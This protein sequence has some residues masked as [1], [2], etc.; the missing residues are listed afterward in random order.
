MTPAKRLDQLD[1]ALKDSSLDLVVCPELFMSGYNIGNALPQL[2]EEQQGAYATQVAKLAISHKIAIVYGYP[3]KDGET[4]FNSA[5]CISANGQ[6]LAN[7]QKILL[8]PGFER[9]FFKPGNK[10]TLFTLRDITC[11]I[12]ICYDAEFP[13][14]IRACAEAGAQLIIVP[15][16]LVDNWSSVAFQLMPTRAFEN[17]VWLMYANHA[18]EENG[19]SYLG[20]SC[21]V[22][23]DGNDAAR[24][25]AEQILIVHEL[26]LEQ[27][28]EA[29]NRLPYLRDVIKLREILSSA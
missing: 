7:H 25:G 6:L 14:A 12:L 28:L 27:V 3:E 18:G 22:A 29:Q 26:D 13:E 2:A 19:A 23:P 4:L 11:A 9:D 20:A 10:L 1:H 16:A 21:I 17:G 5:A 15:T 8:P 24:A